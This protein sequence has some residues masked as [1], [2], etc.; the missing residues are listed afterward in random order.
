MHAGG[1]LAD[2]MLASQSLSRGRKAFAPKATAF[3]AMRGCSGCL[4][5]PSMEIMFSSVAAMLGSAGQA[6]YSAANGWLDVCATLMQGQGLGGHSVQWGPWAEGGMAVASARTAS[7]LRKLGM[8]MLSPSRGLAALAGTVSFVGASPGLA[9]GLMGRTVAALSVDWGIYSQKVTV[10]PHLAGLLEWQGNVVS[11]ARQGSVEQAASNFI[12]TSGEAGPPK[13]G[14]VREILHRV[15]EDVLGSSVGPDDPLMEAGLDS[16]AAVELHSSLQHMVG[17]SLPATL[18][19]DYGSVRAM[20]LFVTEVV[21]EEAA[22]IPCLVPDPEVLSGGGAHA[23]AAWG[24]AALS[25]GGVRPVGVSSSNFRTGQESREVLEVM[26]IDGVQRYLRNDWESPGWT[27]GSQGAYF[28]RLL[29]GVEWFD[30]AAFQLSGSESKWMDPQHRLLLEVAQPVV[31][32]L[33]EAALQGQAPGVTPDRAESVGREGIY[34]GISSM[35]YGRVLSRVSQEASPYAGTGNALSV[36]AGR[37][38]FTFDWQGPSMSVDT[39]CSSSLV[40]THLARVG[41]GRGDC[42]RS[43]SAG[44]NLTLAPDTC[45]VFKLAGML[46]ADG[47]CKTL[48]AAADGYGRGEACGVAGLVAGGQTGRADGQAD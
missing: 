1:A 22:S 13:E 23:T 31:R 43:L 42:H 45:M 14:K 25:A 12:L 2:G 3:A 39:A 11:E 38:S 44:V 17:V 27:P 19:F 48:D 24:P 18:V 29:D 37:M 20:A 46:A 28:G 10:A 7:R 8:Y 32:Q 35:D 5:A 47:R 21:S 30:P 41:L 6:T 40:G 34:V 26:S 9:G 15:V 36:A 16:M 4:A 33:E